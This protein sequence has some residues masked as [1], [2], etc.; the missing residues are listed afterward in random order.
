MP[1]SHPSSL[2]V[3]ALLML[4]HPCARN[5]ATARLLLERAAEHTALTP[6]ERA[7]C[8]SLADDLDLERPEPPEGWVRPH[9]PQ[10]PVTSPEAV[11]RL[12][13]IHS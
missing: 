2:L 12:F 8:R 11:R 9:A 7:A 3:A 10:R 6:A 13:Q 4:R 1:P 5:R